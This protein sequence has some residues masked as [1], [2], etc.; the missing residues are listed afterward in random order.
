MKFIAIPH[1]SVFIIIGGMEL[2]FVHF[3]QF[4][5]KMVRLT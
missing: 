4:H 3:K 5:L 2:I 1:T